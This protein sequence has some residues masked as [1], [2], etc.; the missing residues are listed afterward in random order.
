M[1]VC[2]CVCVSVLCV[3]VCSSSQV[4]IPCMCLLFVEDLWN[5]LG[6]ASGKPVADVMT[7]WTKQMGYPV[8][9]VDAKQVDS[10]LTLPSVDCGQHLPWHVYRKMANVT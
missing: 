9:T 4:Y 2:V 6:V 10:M 8:L 5:A 1:C 3:C 7:T